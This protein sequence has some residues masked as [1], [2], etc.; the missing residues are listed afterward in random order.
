MQSQSIRILLLFWIDWVIFTPMMQQHEMC[1]ETD[2]VFPASRIEQKENM[3]CWPFW[4]SRSEVPNRGAAA[5]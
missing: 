5:H 4:Q 1:V 3:L 2:H